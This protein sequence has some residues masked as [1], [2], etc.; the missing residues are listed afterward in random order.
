M[1]IELTINGKAATLS[2]PATLLDVLQY[3]GIP[4]DRTGVAIAV[5]YDVIPRTAWT[6]TGVNAGDE[7]EVVT[8]T[9]GG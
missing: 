6:E 1:P 2:A 4:T 5:G 8:A 7:V 9:Q 3:L